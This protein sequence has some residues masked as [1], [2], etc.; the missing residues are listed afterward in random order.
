MSVLE[1]TVPTGYFVHQK[2]LDDYVKW[3]EVTTL[4]RARY[5]PEKVYFYFDYVRVTTEKHELIFSSNKYVFNWLKHDIATLLTDVLTWFQFQ[6]EI[7]PTCVNFTLQRWYPVA[8]MT[9]YLSVKVYDYYAPE[10]FNETI[11]EALDLYM[12]DICQVCGSYQCPYCPVFAGSSKITP[13]M[14][15]ILFSSVVFIIFALCTSSTSS[16]SR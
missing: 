14:T 8:N 11:F 6:L 16:S 1:V 4:R 12:L 3:G 10:R 15:V 5:F 9:R 2:R 7:N 13:S